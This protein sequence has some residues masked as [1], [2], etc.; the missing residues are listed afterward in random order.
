MKTKLLI[1]IFNV[2]FLSSCYAARMDGPYEG[3][4][5]DAETGRPIEGVVVLGT[6]YSITITPGGGTHN[7]YDAQEAVT[8]KN[9]DFRIK[10]LGLKVLSNVEPMDALFFKAGY[11][12]DSGSW[13]SFKEGS[14]TKKHKWEGDKVI[15]LLKKLTMEERK[16][17]DT[18]DFYIGRKY[19]KKENI[20]LPCLPKN[21]DLLPKEINKELIEQGREPY[22]LGEG[23]CEK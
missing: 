17:Q 9:G 21:I 19:H 22:D 23:W 1:L 16:K 7:F 13:R 15:I 3:R 2:I 20:T 5:I 6:W 8:N 12:Y 18:P 10:G 4:V 11:E 14:V